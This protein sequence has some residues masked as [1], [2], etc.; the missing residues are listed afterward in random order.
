MLTG[1]VEVR[2][3]R[4]VVQ[5]LVSLRQVPEQNQNKNISASLAI[6]GIQLGST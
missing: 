2:R 5:L 3:R 1:L 4:G 6:A